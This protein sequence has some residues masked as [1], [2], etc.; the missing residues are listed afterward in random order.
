MNEEKELINVVDRLK[1]NILNLSPEAFRKVDF[2][3]KK[4]S[5]GP[6]ESKKKWLSKLSNFIRQ[7]GEI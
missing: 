7:G 1:N 6:E 3:V 5:G 2:L 4:L